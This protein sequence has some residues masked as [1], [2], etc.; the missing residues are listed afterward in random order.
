MSTRR[1][2]DTPFYLGYFKG[3]CTPPVVIGRFYDFFLLG[4]L[5]GVKMKGAK[6]KIQNKIWGQKVYNT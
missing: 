6:Y 2:S 5:R 1:N 4:K 3:S